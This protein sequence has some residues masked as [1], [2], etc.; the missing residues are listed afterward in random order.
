MIVSLASDIYACLVQELE[1]EKSDFDIVKSS[2]KKALKEQ[3]NERDTLTREI[4]RL[5]AS[6]DE[7]RKYITGK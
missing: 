7:E 5:K 1:S 6:L 4:K 2:H 3:D